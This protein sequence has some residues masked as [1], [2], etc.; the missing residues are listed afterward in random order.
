MMVVYRIY[1]YEYI[2]ST[3]YFRVDPQAEHDAI[4]CIIGNDNGNTA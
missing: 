2:E 1:T 4:N 3:E